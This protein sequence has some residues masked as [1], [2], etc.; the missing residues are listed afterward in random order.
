MT[1]KFE[2]LRHDLVATFWNL[3]LGLHLK[4]KLTPQRRK[5]AYAPRKEIAQKKV[6]R[7]MYFF[8]HQELS[9]MFLNQIKLLITPRGRMFVLHAL[10]APTCPCSCSLLRQLIS[11]SIPI[12]LLHGM[13]PRD[14]FS[15]N[16]VTSHR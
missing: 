1:L 12:Q 5:K 15:F 9:D 10:I 4:K 3:R 7:F 16:K 14:Q 2:W 6:Q 13:C 11:F 8:H